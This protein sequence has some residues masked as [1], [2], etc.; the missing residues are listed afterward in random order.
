LRAQR[1]VSPNTL[2]AYQNDL[3][4]FL[5]YLR[6]ADKSLPEIDHLF[7]RRYLAYLGTLDYSKASISRKLSS[8]RS[9]FKFLQMENRITVNIPLLVSSPKKEKRLPSVLSHDDIDI[10]LETPADDTAVGLRDRAIL[11]LLYATGMRASELMSLNLKDINLIQ[12]E[13]KVFGKGS[14]ERIVFFNRLAAEAVTRYLE[15][16]RPV[17]LKKE[18]EPALFLNKNSRRLSIRYLRKLINTYVLKSGIGRKTSPHTL[19]HSFATHVL[20]GGAD[21]RSIQELLGHVDLSTTQVYTHL[22]KDR[23]KGIYRRS[24]PRA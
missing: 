6:R 10:L 14:K 8:V 2:K 20:E 18:K 7:L 3:S 13:I 4:S 23:L 21:L 11:E 22:D 16:S 15:H 5:D 19:R 17:L 1:N 12:G 24:H 9:F